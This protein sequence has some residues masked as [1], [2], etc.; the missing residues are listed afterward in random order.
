MTNWFKG[1]GIRVRIMAL[2]FALMLPL[3]FLIQGFI[4]PTFEEKLY[5]DKKDSTRIAVEIAIGAIEKIH[6]DFKAGKFKDEEEAKSMALK[7]IANIRYNQTEY[8]W[9]N[10]FTPRMIMHPMKPELDGK[11]LSGSKDPN[12]KHLFVEMADTAKKNG[13]GFVEYIWPKP[14]SDKPVEKI[15]YVKEFK[16]WGWIVGNGVYVDDVAG[17]MSALTLKIWTVL[18]IVM[19]LAGLL[20][21]TFSSYLTKKL[22]EISEKVFKGS[23][24]FKETSEDITHSS[25]DI[26]KRTFSSASALQQT[27]AGLFEISNMLKKSVDSADELRKLAVNSKSNVANGKKAVEEM[28]NSMK[29]IFENNDKISDQVSKSNKEMEAIILL[30]QEIAAKTNV[31]NDIVFQTKLLSFNAS[32]E[33]ARAG[34]H[35]RGFAV[36][37]DEIGKLAAMSGVSA[38][39]I[40]QILNQST[41]R[42]NEIIENTK[43]GITLLMD[44]ASKNLDAGLKNADQCGKSLD[45]IVKDSEQVNLMVIEIAQAFKEQSLGVQEINNAMEALDVATQQ[46]AC[47]AKENSES[48]EGLNKDA[49]EM[50]MV[51]REL[52]KIV[53]GQSMVMQKKS[54]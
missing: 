50:E 12:G 49:V 24:N 30:I 8:F 36:V 27:A 37:A 13:A 25:G 19:A 54:A 20:V 34:E 29:S 46:N 32:I 47:S 16:P 42:V 14:N 48:A 35:G 41:S 40:G 3:I 2:M 38:T 11:D 43:S 39:E 6:N 52:I 44:S 51:T 10:D 9:I 5:Q 15:S 18:S 1:Q 23:Q 4:L 33:A 21:F 45:L 31:I 7:V 53:S 17:E 26:T 28:S 22:L